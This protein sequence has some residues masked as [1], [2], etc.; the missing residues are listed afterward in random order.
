MAGVF[1]WVLGSPWVAQTLGEAW[2]WHPEF[3]QI[4][5]RCEMALGSRTLNFKTVS[6]M[7]GRELF[8]GPG[9]LPGLPWLLGALPRPLGKPGLGTRNSGRFL[10]TPN[11]PWGVRLLISKPYPSRMA[12]NFFCV[13]GS[14]WVAPGCSGLSPDPWGSLGL[15]PRIPADFRTLGNGPGESDS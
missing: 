14:P 9:G 5:V 1:F 10:Y 7:D 2:A 3:R 6:L 4:F 13:L 15:A 12:G 8:L 11:W